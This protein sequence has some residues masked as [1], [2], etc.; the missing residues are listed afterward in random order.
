[1]Y[2]IYI[3]LYI[4]IMIIILLLLIAITII[5][6]IIIILMGKD[7]MVG[8]M[9]SPFFQSTLPCKK[10]LATMVSQELLIW[11]FTKIGDPKMDLQNNKIRLY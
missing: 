10:V 11:G 6:I 4:L 5:S 8:T 2:Y 7:S 1:M 9:N 3:H